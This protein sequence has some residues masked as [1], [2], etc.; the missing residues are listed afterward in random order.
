MTTWLID[1]SALACPA[2]IPNATAWASR[3]ERSMV[4]IT[5]VTKLRSALRPVRGRAA[6]RTTPAARLGD[7]DRVP[8]PRHRGPGASESSPCSPTAASTAPYRSPT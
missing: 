1:K 7:A 8:H 3:I 6:H 4:R 2:A 5:T